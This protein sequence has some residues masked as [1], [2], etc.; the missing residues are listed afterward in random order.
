MFSNIRFYFEHMFI[1]FV[2]QK[3]RLTDAKTGKRTYRT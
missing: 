1:I 3:E 2:E